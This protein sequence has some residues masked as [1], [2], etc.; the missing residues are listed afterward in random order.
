MSLSPNID[1]RLRQQADL[2]TVLHPLLGCQPLHVHVGVLGGRLQ[3]V[4]DPPEESRQGVGVPQEEPALT[5]LRP[6][7]KRQREGGHG[8]FP[9]RHEAH[10]GRRDKRLL[11]DTVDD[12]RP[13]RYYESLKMVTTRI[14]W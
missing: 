11:P 12:P 13:V 10:N 2:H 8:H 9:T 3:H 6:D 7:E 1:A 14:T 4:Q 5:G